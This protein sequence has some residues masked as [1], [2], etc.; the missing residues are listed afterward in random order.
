VAERNHVPAESGGHDIFDL[1]SLQAGF[2]DG[3]IEEFVGDFG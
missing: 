1:C 3:L 2:G